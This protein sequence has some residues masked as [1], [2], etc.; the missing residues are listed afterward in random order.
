MPIQPTFW[1]H[2]VAKNAI[3]EGCLEQWAISRSKMSLAQQPQRRTADRVRSD[4]CVGYTLSQTL[5]QVPGECYLSGMQGQFVEVSGQLGSGLILQKAD[6]LHQ[7]QHA[8]P[9]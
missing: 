7:G 8:C 5:A 2:D 4:T 6:H 3:E 1:G 9:S